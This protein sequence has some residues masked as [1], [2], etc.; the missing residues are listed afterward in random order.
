MKF[1]ECLDTNN[2]RIIINFDF[3]I[4][5]KEQDKGCR[6]YVRDDL[7]IDVQQVYQDIYDLIQGSY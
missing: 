4:A 2:K 1:I 6:I 5:I 7:W 3:I